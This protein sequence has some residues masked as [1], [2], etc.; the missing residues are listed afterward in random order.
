MWL[1]AATASSVGALS[2]QNTEASGTSESI[3]MEDDMVQCLGINPSVNHS[4]IITVTPEAKEQ[5]EIIQ[6][7]DDGIVHKHICICSHDGWLI[8]YVVFQFV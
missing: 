5:Y 8:A 1:C 2:D 4:E 7:A 6:N 3:M